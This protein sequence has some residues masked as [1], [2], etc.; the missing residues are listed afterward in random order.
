MMDRINP[1]IS[2]IVPLYNAENT[3][4]ETLHSIAGQ[5]TARTME[6]WI[7]DDGSTDR[8]R[9][10]AQDWIEAMKNRNARLSASLI[11]IEHGG[12]A[13]A[14]NAGLARA[15][16][17]VIAWV[18]S[19]V[20]LDRDWLE[21]LMPELE[22]DRV[23]GAG[24]LLLPAET[25]P[26]IARIFGYEIA[27]KIRSNRADALHITSAN[28]LYRREVFD[29]LGPCRTDL[30]E[31]SFDS[32][33][34]HRL[35][36]A[37][38]R[39]RCNPEARARHHFKTRLSECLIRT[40][41]YG[42]RRPFVQSQVLYPFDRI[43]ALSVLLSGFVWP[44]LILL[45]L[46]P[47][48]FLVVVSGIAAVQILYSLFLYSHFTDSVLLASP[49]IFWLRNSVFLCAYCMGLLYYWTASKSRAG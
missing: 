27:Y 30:G 39:L 45:W 42:F 21:R 15:S 11:A 23:A 34:N 25:D 8:S 26:A 5:N 18:E 29:L 17:P 14:M 49:P 40:W 13:A 41:W 1:D 22:K 44:S 2:F 24:G 38:W 7:V 31:S 37:G 46:N 43:I 36:E 4:R 12:E 33:F 6:I 47:L 28:A 3:V 10:V 32:E 16:A 35:R 9:E 48:A 20:Q 19:D